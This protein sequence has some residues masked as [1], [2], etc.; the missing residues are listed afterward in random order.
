MSIFDLARRP[1]TWLRVA[2]VAVVLAFALDSVAHVVHQHDDSVKTTL[3]AHGPACGY[4]AAFDG[5]V[6]AP[7]HEYAPIA[8]TLI[9][10]YIAPV[11]QFPVSVRTHVSAQPRAPPR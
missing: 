3:S 5:L 2:L 7:K 8:A 10:A 11:T 6:D 9:A 4:C 1:P